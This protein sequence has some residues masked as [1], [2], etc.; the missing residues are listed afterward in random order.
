MPI[1]TEAIVFP[2][3]N[4]VEVRPVLLPDPGPREVGVRT[5]YSG[6]SLG[7]ER[8]CF[9]GSYNRMGQR[10]A[11]A[12]PF[13]TGYQK[14][15]IVDRVGSE[16]SRVKTGDHVILSRTLLLDKD[17]E[18]RSWLGHTGYSVMPEEQVWPVSRGV[19]LASASLFVNPRS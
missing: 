12:Y 8:G 18:Q 5:V 4:V 7:T 11:D 2:A 10:V 6:V 17:L 1:D 19:D 9:T 15:G 13:V 16:V 3:P 14:A